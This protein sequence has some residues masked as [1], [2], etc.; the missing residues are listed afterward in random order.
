MEYVY[1]IFADNKLVYI[2]RTNNI[3]KRRYQHLYNIKHNKGS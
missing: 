1:A 3:K 2:G